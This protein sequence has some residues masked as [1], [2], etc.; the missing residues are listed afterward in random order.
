VEDHHP[1]TEEAPGSREDLHRQFA[2]HLSRALGALGAL[3]ALDESDSRDLEA[4]VSDSS[5]APE[6]RLEAL[7]RHARAVYTKRR[8]GLRKELDRLEPELKELEEKAWRHREYPLYGGR[9]AGTLAL[10]FLIVSFAVAMTTRALPAVMFIVT[11]FVL[12]LITWLIYNP[13]LGRRLQEPYLELLAE[14]KV[15]WREERALEEAYRAYLRREEEAADVARRISLQ[16]G[17]PGT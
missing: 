3:G 8:S 7:S 9:G 13:V 1:S 2:E 15:L 4:R 11:L 5:V 12:C 6:A 10:I 14:T 16:G 17:H